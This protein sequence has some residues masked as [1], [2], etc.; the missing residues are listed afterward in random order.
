MKKF[1]GYLLA[2]ITVLTVVFIIVSCGHKHE[3]TN[4]EIEVE[5]TCSS[6]GTRV[7]GCTKCDY[8]EK[9]SVPGG[10]HSFCEWY[11]WEDESVKRRD[12]A[13]CSLGE[14]NA[15]TDEFGEP[16]NITVGYFPT[17]DVFLQHCDKNNYNNVTYSGSYEYMHVCLTE[18]KISSD[19]YQIH[20]PSYAKGIIFYGNTSGTPIQNLK[21]EIDKRN[22]DIFVDFEDIKIESN[23][24]IFVSESRN[25]TVTT[26]FYW[27]CHFSVT[28]RAQDGFNGSDKTLGDTGTGE[29]TH[30]TRGSDGVPA[31]FINGTFK[32]YSSSGTYIK[33]QDGGNGGNG[34]NVP[35]ENWF[36]YGS[37]GNGGDGGNGGNAIDGENLAII[38]QG[39]P[40]AVTLGGKGGSGGKGGTCHGIGVSKGQDGQN[41]Q[42]GSSGC[43]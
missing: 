39:N 23:D 26:H 3:F 21:I 29:A 11:A 7:R 17:F 20:I 42:D 40:N 15:T 33:G 27:V 25:I 38:V 8:T 35:T 5:A 12:C 13:F 9:A 1:I 2:L 43:N 10:S 30:G 14:I 19:D 32:I 16:I 28:G 41:G 22:S 6:Q 31:M 24:T 34:G 37:G 36:I 4:W 18:G